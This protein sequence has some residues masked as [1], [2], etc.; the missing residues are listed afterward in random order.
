M[1]GK[2]GMVLLKE[3]RGLYSD[4]GVVMVTGVTDIEIAMEAIGLGAID[5]V[6]KPFQVDELLHRVSRAL[7]H[8]RLL[9]ENLAYQ[10][11]LERL[12]RERTTALKHRMQEL[13][14]LNA[15][16][17]RYLDTDL[18]TERKF[19]EL[20]RSLVDIVGQLDDVITETEVRRAKDLVSRHAG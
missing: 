20:S 17:Q 2:S 5:C 15:M 9:Q 10:Q 16:Y 11:D 3:I 4:V 7:E 12:V 19:V 6:T 1:P 8:Q 13:N 18:D 14:G